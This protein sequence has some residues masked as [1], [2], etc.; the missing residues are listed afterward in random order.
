[1]ELICSG[2]ESNALNRGRLGRW[3]GV[4]VTAGLMCAAC[5]KRPGVEFIATAAGHVDPCVEMRVTTTVETVKLRGG[6]TTFGARIQRPSDGVYRVEGHTVYGQRFAA[7]CVVN[8]ADERHN[9][10]LARITRIDSPH[11]DCFGTRD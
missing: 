4:A 8:D 9:V 10:V 11:M 5:C 1:M 7:D 2:R 6:G 3:L